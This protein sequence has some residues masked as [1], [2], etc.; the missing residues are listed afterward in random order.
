VAPRQP[1]HHPAC[2]RRSRSRSPPQPAWR[3][4]AIQQEL[5][6]AALQAAGLQASLSK[7][8]QQLAAASRA[9]K[10]MQG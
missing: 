6:D 10:A 8:K 1:L 7:R 4:H 5:Q 9:L 3:E 2:C